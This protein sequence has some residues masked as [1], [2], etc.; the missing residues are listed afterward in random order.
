MGRRLLRPFG[1]H[2]YRDHKLQRSVSVG[3]DLTLELITPQAQ[4][5][6][7]QERVP[8]GTRAPPGLQG[9]Q[10]SCR[11]HS[12]RASPAR[13]YPSLSAPVDVCVGLRADSVL[14]WTAV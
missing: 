11:Q 7:F 3:E 5:V 4:R 14:R 6:V 8:P 1:N 10:L 12:C 9:T 13:L 2:A